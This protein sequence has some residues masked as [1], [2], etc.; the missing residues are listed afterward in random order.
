MHVFGQQNLGGA[1]TRA[2]KSGGIVV[3]PTASG[4][5]GEFAVA[6]VAE[7]VHLSIVAI[8]GARPFRRPDF[9]VGR[10]DGIY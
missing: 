8:H 4:A 7:C 9:T 6:A 5:G 3:V 2:E 1:A 10:F